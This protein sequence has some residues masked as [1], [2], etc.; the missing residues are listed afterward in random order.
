MLELKKIQKKFDR[1][2]VVRG[3]SLVVPQGELLSILGPSGCGKTTLLRIL[4]G[5]ESP[6]SGS[7]WFDGRDITAMAPNR[8]PFNMVFQ[9]YALFPHLSVE[10]N[11]AFGPRIRGEKG[12]AL[13][14]R[15]AEALELVRLD[16]FGSRSISNLSGGQQQRV[17]LARAIINRPQVLLLDEPMSA[18]DRNLRE[19]MRLDIIQIQR[20]LGITFIMVTHDQEEAMAMSDRIA[21][22]NEGVIEQIGPPESIYRSPS[23]SFVAQSIGT[24]NKLSIEGRNVYV[25]PE[26]VRIARKSH[27]RLTGDVDNLS[28][29]VR[30]V[31]FKGPVTHY[32]LELLHASN[33]EPLTATTFGDVHQG[34]QFL[35]DDV[36]SISWDKAREINLGSLGQEP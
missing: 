36:V 7:I 30:E 33:H 10:D 19:K 34:E 11:V 32:V 4:S 14:K 12:L 22:M 24:L 31:L 3:V 18:L 17:A 35:V 16:G 15:V 29:V 1:E 20:K 28:A 5:F 26:N 21:I 25:R 2:A 6:D 13:A 9:R 8:R 23:T 27:S